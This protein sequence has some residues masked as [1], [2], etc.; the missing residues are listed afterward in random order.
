M[1]CTS[2]IPSMD[3]FFLSFQLSST[4]VQNMYITS[5]AHRCSFY[6]NAEVNPFRNHICRNIHVTLSSCTLEFIHELYQT[7]IISFSLL[8]VRHS[9]MYV[10]FV[11]HCL[12]VCSITSS[13]QSFPI[14]L[15][16][17]FCTT[18]GSF[19]PSFS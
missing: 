13:N 9:T 4:I 6:A 12:T 11:L 17:W 14:F 15:H 16:H 8:F 3:V 7:F 5:S 2:L 18:R 1:P 19:I 10:F